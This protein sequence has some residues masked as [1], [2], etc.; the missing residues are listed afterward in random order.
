M[1]LDRI[2]TRVFRCKHHFPIFTLR[3]FENL[4]TTTSEW[5]LAESISFCCLNFCFRARIVFFSS[6]FQFL[7]DVNNYRFWSHSK[8]QKYFPNESAVCSERST[9]LKLVVG[10]LNICTK[11]RLSVRKPET[12]FSMRVCNGKV[13]S[14]NF[15]LSWRETIFELVSLCCSVSTEKLVPFFNCIW[16]FEFEIVDVSFLNSELPFRMSFLRW[17]LIYVQLIS[18]GVFGLAQDFTSNVELRS[19][20]YNLFCCKLN[21]VRQ[22]E[23]TSGLKQ[24]DVSYCF[25]KWFWAHPDLYNKRVI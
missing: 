2:S 12:H 25:I 22:F 9:V 8:E 15:A 5:E 6:T 17:C 21:Q 23:K 14:E 1:D 10:L 19:Q 13:F 24:W 18:N 4:A 16:M 3:W 20:D 11:K 7:T